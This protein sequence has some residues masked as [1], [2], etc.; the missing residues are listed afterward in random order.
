[1]STLK[2]NTLQTNTGSSFNI[3]SQLG[4]IPAIDV[5]GGAV[6][7]A[8][9]NVTGV[10]TFAGGVSASQGVDATGLRVTGIS[11]LGQ[12][13]TA[14]FV[15]AGISTLGDATASTLVISGVSTFTTVKVGTAA[16]IDS[17]GINVTGVITTSQLSG[18]CLATIDNMSGIHTL[19][20]TTAASTSITLRH[21]N[22]TSNISNG[23]FVV[24]TGITVGTTVSAG[25]GTSSLTL[26]L[27]VGI[28]STANRLAFYKHDK[29]VTPA[30]IGGQLCR[31]WVNFSGT[32][33]VFI[34]SSY[35]VSSITD[36]DVGDYTVNF[37]TAMPDSNYSPSAV[38]SLTSSASNNY[39]YGIKSTGTTSITNMT[40]S[41]YRFKTGWS[42]NNQL[43]D[44]A[45]VSIQIFR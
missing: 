6:F 44:A 35:N 17:S 22:Q 31:V 8:G 11:T 2:V 39:A 36:N 3:G 26:S 14:G 34:R 20:V 1:M 32:D 29:I 27:P 37:T 18:G 45:L 30:I 23:D 38:I 10:S 40:T 24:G 19:G 7:G 41:S 4:V 25:A 21:P 13:T 42:N 33:T 5:T 43:D 15:N 28:N 9:I 16:T 12:T